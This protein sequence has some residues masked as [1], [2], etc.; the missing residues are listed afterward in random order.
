MIAENGQLAIHLPL[1]HARV[2]AFSTHTAH[3]DVITLMQQILRSSLGVSF[4]VMNPFLY[5][6]K[7]EVVAS[8]WRSFRQG[9]AVSSSC[10]KNSRLSG[11]ATHCGECIPCYVRRVAIE[12]H[13]NDPT[14]YA[15]NIFIENVRSLPPDD[16]G[17]RN[18]IDLCEF[19]VHFRGQS[20]IELMS[21]WPELYSENIDAAEV[22]NMYRRAAD[23]TIAVLSRYQGIAPLIQ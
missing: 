10:W 12:I 15:R 5:R 6:T 7:S 22:I 3:P 18:L 4:E 14:A 21:A 19:S 17:R 1:N 20:E 8:L 13:G 23:Q 11:G 9:I 2:G 16:E